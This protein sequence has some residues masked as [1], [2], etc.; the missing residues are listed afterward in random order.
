MKKTDNYTNVMKSCKTP[1]IYVN[2]Y[3]CI[4]IHVVYTGQSECKHSLE[5]KIID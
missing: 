2:C 3:L 4:E 1:N 5:A